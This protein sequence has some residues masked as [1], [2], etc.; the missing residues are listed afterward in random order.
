MTRHP[1][2]R[3]VHREDSAPDDVFLAGVLE[4]SA[5]AKRHQR[6]LIIAGITVAV[7]VTALVLWLN[8]RS[9]L[10]ERAAVELTQVRATAMAG[11]PELAIRDLE[12][13]L[14]TYGGTPSGVEGRLMLGS[15]YLEVGRAADAIE[16][17]RP[18]ARNVGTDMGA[19]AAFLLASAHEAAGEPH[20]AE[21]VY[22]RIGT[23]GRF[24][25]QRQ[26]A[27]DHAARLRLQRGDVAGAVQLYE[28]LVDMTPETSQDRQIFELRL[29]EAR[30]LAVSGPQTPAAAEETAAPAEPP[31]PPGEPEGS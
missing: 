9:S 20:R 11:Q 14:A 25:F 3:R 8:Q 10:R 28:R 29:G 21:E 12:Q 13:F 19:N 22:L 18:V 4:T 16:T 23:G 27:L 31:A 30:A 6:T 17:V 15:T 1:T 26:E 24:L 5:W 2:A 7:V